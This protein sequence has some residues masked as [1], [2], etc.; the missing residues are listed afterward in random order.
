VGH[1]KVDSIESV[2]PSFFHA[3]GVCG[4]QTFL[5]VSLSGAHSEMYS[6]VGSLLRCV[7]ASGFVPFDTRKVVNPR[8]LKRSISPFRNGYSVGSPARLMATC[9]G[10][11]ASRYLC[12]VVLG[13]LLYPL[14][15]F[16]CV[17]MHPSTM[18]SGSSQ[19]GEAVSFH[20]VL[21]SP[22][23]IRQQKLHLKSHCATV[24]VI[25][26]HLWLFIP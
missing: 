19:F 5:K 23:W 10:S 26:M 15:S 13:L 16:R 11:V 21:R 12:V 7:N 3:S 2:W 4:R 8:L 22:L 1:L 9:L 25:W 17:F 24:G 6:C 18:V 14:T 20:F